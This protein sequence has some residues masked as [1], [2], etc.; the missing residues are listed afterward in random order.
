MFENLSCDE[1]L[2]IFSRGGSQ[3]ANE[4][5]RQPIWLWCPKSGFVGR[6]RLELTVNEAVI[7][8]NDGEHCRLTIFEVLGLSA[9]RHL[10]EGLRKMNTK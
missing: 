4:S 8:Y 1:F 10:Q 5:F 6:K 2:K 7:V 3:N 9:G